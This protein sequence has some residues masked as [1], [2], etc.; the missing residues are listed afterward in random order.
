MKK[1]GKKQNSAL[2]TYML[3]VSGLM[4][5]SAAGYAQ[6][7]E[8]RS[9]AADTLSFVMEEV[10]VTARRK[11][12]TLST[13]PAAI[14]AFGA[15]QLEKRGITTDSDLQL[16]TPGL[17]IRQ[18]QGQNSLTYA[19]RGQT[20]DS[21]SSSPSAVIAYMNEVPLTIG[22]ASTFFD[23]ES[24]QVLKGP[25]G[26]LFGRNATGGAVLYTSA[27]PVNEFAGSLRV[28]AGNYD[29]LD[30]DGMINIP[31]VDDKV[32]L[33]AAFNLYKRD[34]YI[35]NLLTGDQLGTSDRDSGR[36]SLLMRP[37]ENIESTTVFQYSRSEGTNTGA[38]YTYSVYACGDTNNGF[39]LTCNAGLLFGPGLDFVTGAGSWDA[40]LAAHPEAYAGG[41]IAY[42]EEQERIGA[43]KTRHPGGA[44]H[45]SEDWMLSNTTTVEIS[46]TFRIKNIIGFSETE[47]DSQQPQ[48]GAPFVTIL[49]ANAA[50]GEFGNEL[51]VDSFTEE[52]QVSG[53]AFDNK[54]SYIAGIYIQRVDSKTVWPQTY[55]DVSPIIPPAYVTNAFG[56][57]NET[58]AAYAQGT[59][60]LSNMI[61][62]LKFTAGF[63]YTIE[64]V[65]I[66]QLEE[67]TYTFGAPDQD[68]KFQDPSWE[69]GFEYQASPS[70]FAYIKT[71]GSFRS[72][73]FNGAAPPV[74]ADATG[75]GNIFYSEHTQD[76]ELGV[77][78]SDTLWGRPFSLNLDVYRQWVQD[79]QRVEFPD[80]DGPGGLASIA[81]T[82]NVPSAR[83][84]GIE[85]DI[86]FMPAPWLHIGAA[87]AITDAEFTDGEIKLFGSPF[88]YGPV[89]DTP[90]TTGVLYAEVDIPVN[91]AL[92]NLGLRGEIYSQSSMY[93]S[94]AA[95]SIAP[96]T[97]LP[98]YTLL[99][100]RIEL[101][102]IMSTPL[103]AAFFAK[104]ILN[105]EYFAGGMTLAAALG[106]NAAAVGEPRTFGFELSYKF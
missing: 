32:L 48:L 103:T 8:T 21:F 38:S 99:N 68:R 89:G 4:L 14:T 13:V 98:G 5:H 87:G 6:S 36:L 26:T 96:G 64:R 15:S 93:F 34:G 94:N 105:K 23:L 63:R 25:Q 37:T 9:E 45:Y 60:D 74:N 70:V 31:V 73:G 77:K 2:W 57:R 85:A 59:Y 84:Q 104:N 54:L 81:V 95:N 75:G 12:E 28:R 62:G 91:D 106:H 39:A 11:S 19:I 102:E 83:I 17:T 30:I 82:A 69:V 100:G 1:I 29:L 42:L 78:I 40:Y 65:S 18:T 3:S 33:R 72:G 61:E 35:D 71:R 76:V 67:A 80:P 55:F 101:S 53:E 56:I 24:V 90:K 27:K 47:V 43:F 22:A 92:G 20:A 66:E 49:T 44:D 88:Q 52:F 41:L 10:V 86:S 97:K 79:V 50:S 7:A 51:Y 58:D 16:V 46:D